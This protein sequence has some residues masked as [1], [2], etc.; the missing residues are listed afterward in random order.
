MVT[1]DYAAALHQP[2]ACRDHRLDKTSK[3]YARSNILRSILVRIYSI[4]RDSFCC[5]D[6][7]ASRSFTVNLLTG[8]V[9]PSRRV[10]PNSG[11]PR[12]SLRVYARSNELECIPRL[13][14]DKTR[15]YTRSNILQHSGSRSIVTKPWMYGPRSTRYD[16]RHESNRETI[17]TRDHP[18][19]LH[20]PLVCRDHRLDD[21][22][23]HTRSNELDHSGLLLL[24]RSHGR[25]DRAIVR[26][27]SNAETMVSGTTPRRSTDPSH[28]EIIAE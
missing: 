20:W 18:P 23:V 6:I 13:L 10:L 9:G 8:T 25:I 21:T 28:A 14:L 24:S 2:L 19:A 15:V 5:P 26:R 16:H 22:G 3:V 1:W 12:L 27:E 11:M 7:D 4:T 17:I